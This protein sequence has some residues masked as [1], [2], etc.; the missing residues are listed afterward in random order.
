MWKI[1]SSNTNWTTWLW[2]TPA[3]GMSFNKRE[4]T[5]NEKRMLN[6]FRID[7]LHESRYFEKIKNKKINLCGLQ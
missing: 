3:E 1:M 5:D 4:S 7:I 2:K 6:F